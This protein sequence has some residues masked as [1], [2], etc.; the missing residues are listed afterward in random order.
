MTRVF[1]TNTTVPPN[2]ASTRK[3]KEHLVL[4]RKSKLDH[5][6]V[7]HLV[8]PVIGIEFAGDLPHL[9]VLRV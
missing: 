5:T 8:Y 1:K 3:V 7:R 4:C 9:K 2:L 6:S